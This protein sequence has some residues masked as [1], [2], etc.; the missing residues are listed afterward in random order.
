MTTINAD[1]LMVCAK[2]LGMGICLGLTLDGVSWLWSFFTDSARG[3][4]R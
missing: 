4:I 1:I 3:V 2:G